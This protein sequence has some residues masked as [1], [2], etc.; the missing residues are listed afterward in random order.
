MK[1]WWLFAVT[2]IWASC[3]SPSK[4]ASDDVCLLL[5]SLF[6]QTDLLEHSLGQ[7]PISWPAVESAMDQ[8]L[9]LMERNQHSAPAACSYLDHRIHPE[10]ERFLFVDLLTEASITDTMPKI[11]FYLVRLR[12]IY[13]QDPEIFEY[14]SEE[15]AHVGFANPVAYLQYLQQFPEQKSL[16]LNSSRWNP[17]NAAKLMAKFEPLP[18]SGPVI[19]FLQSRFPDLRT[20]P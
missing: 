1:G 15:M 14:L 7:D 17:S 6:D 8:S 5:D 9:Q 4:E 16:I 12:S 13:G 3:A 11:L 2:L 20:A 18:E 19:A 10:K